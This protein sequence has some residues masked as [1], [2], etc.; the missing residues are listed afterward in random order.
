MTERAQILGAEPAET[1]QLLWG[2]LGHE[3]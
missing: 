3:R 1:A 2:L